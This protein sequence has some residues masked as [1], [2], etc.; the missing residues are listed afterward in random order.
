MCKFFYVF[1]RNFCLH[2]EGVRP[3]TDLNWC[4]KLDLSSIPRSFAI[5]ETGTSGKSRSIFLASAIRSSF[6]QERNDLWNFREQYEQSSFLVRPRSSRIMSIEQYRSR[7][8]PSET[9]LASLF[10]T[11]AMD[12]LVDARSSERLF[13][14]LRMRFS[15]IDRCG[16]RSFSLSLFIFTGVSGIVM[17]KLEKIDYFCKVVL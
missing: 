14:F 17:T 12:F 1:L 8:L 9:H 2:S 7:Y 13:L 11:I 5:L 10:S 4:L 15:L 16:S 3:V 6:L